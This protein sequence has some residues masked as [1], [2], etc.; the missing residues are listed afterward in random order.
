MSAQLSDLTYLDTLIK[1]FIDVSHSVWKIAGVKEAYLVL[2][3]FS[4]GVDHTCANNVTPHVY[5][6]DNDTFS[7]AKYTTLLSYS[8]TRC[9][10][11][12][13]TVCLF[14]DDAH[15]NTGDA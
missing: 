6:E 1:V 13:D 4:N 3:A 8:S 10:I 14:N 2:Y 9:E 15:Q 12:A 5:Y 11:S 7:S